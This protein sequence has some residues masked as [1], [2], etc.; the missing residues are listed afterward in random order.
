MRNGRFVV[1]VLAIVVACSRTPSGP[2]ALKP[3]VTTGTTRSLK[4]V[5]PSSLAPGASA[6]F[7]TIATLADGT[8]RDD[9]SRTLWSVS[10][11]SIL[12]IS[13]TGVAVAGARGLTFLA[14]TADNVKATTPVT[15]LPDGTFVLSGTVKEAGVAIAGAT[16]TVTS[17]DQA[18]T[19]GVS[20]IG[21]NY[22]LYGVAGTFNVEVSKDGYTTIVQSIVV[23]SPTVQNFEL[24]PSNPSV[25]A[26]TYSATLTADG[27]CPAAGPAALADD[28]R[29][30][31]YSAVIT[32]T[33][34]TFHAVLGS[35]KFFL[36][37][38]TGDGFFGRVGPSGITFTMGDGYYTP[39]A[40]FVEIIDTGR[41]LL[42]SGTGTF[43]RNDATGDLTGTF[44]G[45]I[46]EGKGTNLWQNNWFTSSCFAKQHR[47]LF[48]RTG[49][50]SSRRVRP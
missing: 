21:G 13:S 8:T 11:P 27:V 4:I 42:V 49:A 35:A 32:Q 3:A 5:G 25:I 18:G 41:V 40:D 39:Q 22:R 15:V 19:S 38:G 26:G 36:V 46:V 29:T 44:S 24:A 20:D 16:V 9:S 17:G 30:R 23:S 31:H 2:T 43:V 1:L 10:D 47:L 12:K 6:Q 37:N 7:S 14:A 28:V 45:D 33:G 50:A 34:P 48:T